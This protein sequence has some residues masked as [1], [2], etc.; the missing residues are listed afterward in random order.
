MKFLS[1]ITNIIRF[2][3]CDEENIDDAEVKR[4]VYDDDADEDD[5]DTS[6]VLSGSFIND[7]EYTQRESIGGG[8]GSKGPFSQQAMYLA[9]NRRQ[10]ELDSPDDDRLVFKQSYDRGSRGDDSID[11]S[12]VVHSPSVSF[13]NA[14]ETFETSFEANTSWQQNAPAG[15]DLTFDHGIAMETNSISAK[16]TAR[17]LNRLEPN[18]RNN[19]GNIIASSKRKADFLCYSSSSD[20][21]L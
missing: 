11:E 5:A 14:D 6:G 20:S 9:I 17:R 15:E 10:M 18:S 2:S 13:E 8:S 3:D 12:F 16:P 1:P 19:I 4:R 7:G 21:E